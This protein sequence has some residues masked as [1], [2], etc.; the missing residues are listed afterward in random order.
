MT[1]PVRTRRKNKFNFLKEAERLESFD[2]FP[3]LRPEIDPQ[4][5]VSR[6]SVDQP[7]YLRCA[8]DS[9]IAQPTGYS[10]IEFVEGPTRY[11]D[12]E[13]GDFVYVP[14]GTAHRILT[15]REGIILRYKA[16]DF[17]EET[18]LWYCPQCQTELYRHEIVEGQSVQ[19][20]YAA[21]CSAFNANADARSCKACGDVRPPIDMT[22]FRW[23]AVAGALL[24]EAET[25]TE[26]E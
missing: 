26:N 2:E 23:D 19:A 16:R 12:T 7:F 15:T 18:V 21:A 5:H 8:K 10:R 14:A 17:G 20:G 11:F 6:N 13:P 3:M 24:A 1:Q 22:P 9:V 25:S 4:L